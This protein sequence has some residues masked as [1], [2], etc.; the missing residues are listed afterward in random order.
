[1]KVT[2]VAKKCIRFVGPAGII[3]S[4]VHWCW[5]EVKQ[6]NPRVAKAGSRKYYPA[7]GNHI[8]LRTRQSY[9]YGM[10]VAR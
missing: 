3:P 2:K 10:P 6:G 9:G 8:R 1:M 7:F 4:D 5:T